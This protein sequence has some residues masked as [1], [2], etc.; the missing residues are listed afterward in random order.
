MTVRDLRYGHK[1]RDMRGLDLV[2]GA[3]QLVGRDQQVL[4]L[5]IY[6]LLSPLF[7]AIASS[8]A[9]LKHCVNISKIQYSLAE[10]VCDE[11]CM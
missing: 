11:L 3:L 5:Y 7:P 4:S 6:C 8:V 1:H 9:N 2:S 10:S